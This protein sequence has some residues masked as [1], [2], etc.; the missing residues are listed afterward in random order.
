M[1]D[2]Q[3]NEQ[4]PEKPEHE[5]VPAHSTEEERERLKDVNKDGIPPGIC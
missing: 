5:D 1:T 3:T 4:Q 2:P